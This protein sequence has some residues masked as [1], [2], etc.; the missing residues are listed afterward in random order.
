MTKKAIYTVL[1]AG[2]GVSPALAQLNSSVNVEGEYQPLV[3]E[4]QRLNTFPKGYRFELPPANL[5]FE[6]NG[7]VSDFRPSLLTMGVTGR[8]TDWP[9]KQRHGFVDFRMGSYLNTHLD[10]GYNIIAD[11]RQ[12]LSAGL[13]YVMSTLYRPSGVPD[14]FTPMPLKRLYDGGLDLTYTRLFGE[15]GILR[16][17][18]GYDAAYF[19]YY[20]TTLPKDY[21]LFAGKEINIPTQTLNEVSADVDFTSSPSFIKGWHAGAAVNYLAYRRFYAPA[22]T[23]SSVAGDRETELKI[24]GGYAFN[25]AGQSAINLDANLDFIFYNK[26]KEDATIQSNY[27]PRNYSIVSLKPSYRYSN[28]AFS[29]QAGVNLDFSYDAMGAQPDKKFAA[30]HLAPDVEIA[31]K[32][33]AGIGIKLSATGGVTP[34]TLQLRKQF[35]RYQLPIVVTT[36]PVYSPLDANLSFNT[37]PFYGFDAS[38]SLRY[39][40]ANNVPLGG[41]Y[42]AFLGTYPRLS[43]YVDAS[44]Y[45]SPYMKSV[46]LK[47][48]SVNLNLH[49]AFGTMVDIRFDATYTPQNGEKGIFNGF[50]RPRW[51]LDAS[52]EVRPIKKLKLQV[53][54]GYRGVRNCYSW[55]HSD[56]SKELTAFRLPDLTD[57]NAKITYSILDNLE[58]YCKGENLLNNRKDFLPGLQTEGVVVA[59]GIYFEF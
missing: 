56:T 9:Q 18:L 33:D 8:L 10:A 1:L 46:D 39:A 20:G 22:Q 59:G 36:L 27:D 51:I 55:I 32:S 31:Y 25:F 28:N 15:E 48:L 5:E 54:Y 6:Y 35:D 34:S 50:D 38:V 44:T 4:T 43:Q 23:G 3:I 58:I 24:N 11:N 45:L 16:A 26:R 13:H 7:V 49:Y 40:I 42:Q 12:T 47:G 14:N 52:A 2:L 41:W 57:L 19:N 53:G 21:I 17:N 37:G 30:F 29:M